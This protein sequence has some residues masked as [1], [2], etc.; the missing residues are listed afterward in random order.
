MVSEEMSSKSGRGL[1]RY[2][3]DCE[4]RSF[5]QASRGEID[6]PPALIASTPLAAYGHWLGERSARNSLT[7]AS[8]LRD[9][10]DIQS[11]I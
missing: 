7:K 9:E 6:D 5:I 11:T 1:D 10:I 2:C 4:S 3:G 8:L